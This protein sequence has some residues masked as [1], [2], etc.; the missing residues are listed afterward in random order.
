MASPTEPHCQHDCSRGHSSQPTTLNS[1]TH[2]GSCRLTVHLGPSTHGTCG[3]WIHRQLLTS[4]FFFSARQD[5]VALPF[6]Q[7]CN[8]NCGPR[9]T[10]TPTH[11]LRGTRPSSLF[12]PP[13]PCCSVSHVIAAGL[14][15]ATSYRSSF[16]PPL[17]GGAMWR[18]LLASSSS[19]VDRD[20]SYTDRGVRPSTAL[21][22]H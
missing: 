2:P 5:Q 15:V 11:W 17:W 13:R 19:A 7:H 21:I 4:P 22:G 20:P 10:H 14:L 16:P 3:R 9:C 1:S 8:C 12:A 18:P 6:L